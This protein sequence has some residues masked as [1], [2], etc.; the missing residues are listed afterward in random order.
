M[1]TIEIQSPP[2]PKP[3]I[4]KRSSR[5]LLFSLAGLTFLLFTY[6]TVLL[7]N[8]PFNQQGLI[9]VLQ[10]RSVRS[11]TIGR[12]YPTYFPPGCVAEDIRFLH[13]KQ[14]NKPPL[15]TI[16]K[17]VI[18][19]SYTGLLTIQNRLA[20]VRVFGL[21]VTVPP[22]QPDGQPNPI[23]PL[24]YSKSASNLIIDKLVADGTHL[25]F[26]PTNP[27]EKRFQ[28][29]ID[30]LS[31]LEVG[32]NRPMNYRALVSNTVPPGK[33]HSNGKFGPWNPNAPGQT[34]LSGS[35]TVSNTNLGFFQ[36]LNGILSASGNFQGILGAIQTEGTAD[37]QNFQLTGTNH[38]RPLAARFHTVVDATNGNTSLQNLTAHFDKTTATF[39]GAIAT[40]NGE[41]G[42]TVSLNILAANARIE[43]LLNLFVSAKRPAMNGSLTM[44][45]HMD[46][47]P[48]LPSHPQ[49]FVT[50]LKFEG[51]F[52][53]EGA[54]LSD[55]ATESGLT[56]LSASA[57][58]TKETDPEDSTRV[59]SDLK[60]HVSAKAGTAALSKASFSV[61]GAKA[62]LH[63]TYRL[64]N[65]NLDLYGVMQTTGDPSDATTGFKSFLVKAI[66][67]FLKKKG[68]EHV[69]PFKITGKSDA[70]Q[71]GLDL[72]AK[73]QPNPSAQPR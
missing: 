18:A 46:L 21:H 10:Q 45:G 67:P 17:L 43:D 63:G 36:G 16:Q 55:H 11:V 6:L 12:F 9:D 5:S 64:T 8:W 32:D 15:I 30:K 27:S 66:T 3:G 69:V 59:L 73:N 41:H 48:D 51:D 47:P 4:F 57:T 70:P 72:G 29:F 22:E 39:N 37:V 56:R 7:L 28:L 34:P 50:K 60:G 13:R 52:G 31:L 26:V 1:S 25:E 23:M 61:P 49:P 20:L 44:R 71:I 68:T 2:A 33:I 14:K 53:V 65:F 42:K 38:T 24:N 40:Q 58:K 62:Q 19:G 35:Y 54:K